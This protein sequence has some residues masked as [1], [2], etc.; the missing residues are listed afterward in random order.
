MANRSK[1][2]RDILI[3]AAATLFAKHT[4]DANEI[5]I[6]AGQ[7]LSLSPPLVERRTALERGVRH[8]RVRR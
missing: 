7:L 6:P 4:R 8:S 5:A 1:A 3:T 2:E